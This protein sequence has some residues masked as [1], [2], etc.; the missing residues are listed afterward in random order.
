MKKLNKVDNLL[1]KYISAIAEAAEEIKTAD[2]QAATRACASLSGTSG[3][4]KEKTVLKFRTIQDG[5]TF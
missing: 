1:D 2:S 4:P 5:P 3:Q